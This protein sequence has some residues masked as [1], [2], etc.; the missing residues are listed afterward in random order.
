METLANYC[1]QWTARKGVEECYTAYQKYGLTLEEF[2]GPRY[3]RLAHIHM[4][5]RQGVIDND[6]RFVIPR[7]AEW[8]PAE[9]Q[10]GNSRKRTQRERK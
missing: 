8:P 9:S 4:L 3:Q 7:S 5:I 1:P 6:L 10:E 2:E